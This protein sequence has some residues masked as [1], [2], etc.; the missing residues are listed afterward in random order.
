LKLN[1]GCGSKLLNGYLNIDKYPASELV[2]KGDLTTGIPLE[3]ACADEILLDNVIE[4]VTSVVD[5]MREAHRLLKT[6]GVLRILTPHYSSQASWRDPTHLHHLSYFSFDY[7]TGDKPYIP[8]CAFKVL[9]KQMSF[10]GGWSSF[11]R[12]IFHL[13]PNRYEKNFAFIFPASTIRVTMQK[14]TLSCDKASSNPTRLQDI[15]AE[16]GGGEPLDSS[17]APVTKR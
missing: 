12:F 5:S 13:S 3:S 7:F 1:I 10:G 11:G 2:L 15:G 6:G 16:L 9:E 14:V 8:D 4:H 17:L